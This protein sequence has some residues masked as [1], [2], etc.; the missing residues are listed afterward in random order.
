MDTI[1]HGRVNT[2]KNAVCLTNWD[3]H[4]CFIILAV[5]QCW[6]HVHVAYT[7]RQFSG[8]KRQTRSLTFSQMLGYNITNIHFN[9]CV[10]LFFCVLLNTFV[11]FPADGGKT[12]TF[13]NNDFRGDFQTVTFEDPEIKKLFFGSFHKV[14]MPLCVCFLPDFLYTD[15]HISWS[16]CSDA[17]KM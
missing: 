12:L 10:F 9:V 13:F 1:T 8:W 3:L 7:S 14:R 16:G 17:Y 4:Y 5:I 15:L 2:E 6:L 11:Y